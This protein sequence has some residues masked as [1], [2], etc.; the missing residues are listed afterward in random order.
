MMKRRLRRDLTAV[1]QYLEGAYKKDGER[2]FIVVCSD[3][4]PW[5]V[6]IGQGVMVLK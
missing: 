3:S 4:L 5:S 6:V 1:F 2:L